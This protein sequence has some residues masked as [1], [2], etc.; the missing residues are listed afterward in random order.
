MDPAQERN[1]TLAALQEA[2]DRLKS[3]VNTRLIPAEGISFGYALRGAGDAGG[4]AAVRGGIRSTP[5]GITGGTIAFGT[6]DPVVRIIL[7][8]MRFDPV[9]RSAAI[10]QHS[11]RASR[12]LE[13]DMFLEC[14]AISPAPDHGISTMDWG[15]ASCCRDGVPEVILR[16]GENELDSR[17]ILTGGSPAD[18]SNNIIIC[19]NRV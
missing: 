11:E 16:R 15:I 1:R 17:I 8:I 3:S 7:T 9:V 2:V 13:D 12:I 4:I 14:V 6:S 5:E 18:V 10:L 19:S